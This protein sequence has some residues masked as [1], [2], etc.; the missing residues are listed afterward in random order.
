MGTYGKLT[1]EQARDAAA[2]V[3]AKAELGE[4]VAGARA[5]QRAEMTVA[6]LCDEYVAEG[7]EGKKPSTLAT[8]K[9]RIERHIKPLLGRKRIGE[10]VRADVE[11]FLRDVAN[12]KTAIDERTKSMAARS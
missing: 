10:V 5:K 1:V 6:Q 3:L 11:R 9:G 8:D 12:G 7:C 4:D 2:K